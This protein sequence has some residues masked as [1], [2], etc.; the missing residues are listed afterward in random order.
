MLPSVTGLSLGTLR[1][2]VPIETDVN[3]FP[4]PSFIKAHMYVH[5]DDGAV[6]DF[7]LHILNEFLH[8]GT[9][10][11][12][13]GMLHIMPI[14]KKDNVASIRLLGEE[15]SLVCTI[16]NPEELRKLSDFSADSNPLT[17]VA[18]HRVKV[19]FTSYNGIGLK[20]D[21]TPT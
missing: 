3:V 5:T 6:Y 9:F 4:R 11:S 1:S 16:E 7:P 19:K 17:L 2:P 18:N 13:T 15:H 14:L 10:V 20:L 12:T 21:V 8:G